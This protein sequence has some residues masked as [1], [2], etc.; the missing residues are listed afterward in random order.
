MIIYKA[1]NLVNGRCYIGQTIQKLENRQKHHIRASRE[2]Y[3]NMV[4]HK[5]IRKY[6]IDNI[7]WEILCECSDKNEMDFMEKYFIRFYNSKT[8]NGYNITDGGDGC[9]GYKHTEKHKKYI[10]EKLKGYKHSEEAKKR[11]GES[12]RGKKNA[13]WIW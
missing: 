13:I 3:D 4:F 1:I 9:F 2:N 6:G 8:P 11:M 7:S 12:G 5:A 10:G